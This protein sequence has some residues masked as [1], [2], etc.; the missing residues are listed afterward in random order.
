MVGLD[1]NSG[2]TLA[3]TGTSGTRRWMRSVGR[4]EI[5]ASRRFE[6]HHEVDGKV[7]QHE[8][9]GDDLRI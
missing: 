4:N 1:T 2:R 8:E 9:R 6:E 5:I 7:G 3:T